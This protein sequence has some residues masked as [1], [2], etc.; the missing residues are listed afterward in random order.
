[1]ENIQGVGFPATTGSFKPE[2]V[3][4]APQRTETITEEESLPPQKEESQDDKIRRVFGLIESSNNPNAI[5]QKGKGSHYGLYQFS[6]DTARDYD[7]NITKED[8]FKPDVQNKLLSLHL[9]RVEK[10]LQ[11]PEGQKPT[12]ADLYLGHQ[13]GVSGYNE[14]MRF[15]D[16]PISKMKNKNRQK[17]I[18]SN[19]LKVTKKR[20]NPTIGDFINDWTN[21]INEKLEK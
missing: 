14:I 5:S 17:A 9:K 20:E 1:M 21:H 15:K 12:I 19:M 7:K 18:K 16:R 10:G 13:Q 6:L 2:L 4:S 8:L 11:L 3:T